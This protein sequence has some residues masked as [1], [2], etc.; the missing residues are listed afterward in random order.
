MRETLCHI[1]DKRTTT[2]WGT[3]SKSR[4]SYEYDPG[5][6]SEARKTVRQVRDKPELTTSHI[7]F[8][9]HTLIDADGPC[10]KSVVK[11]SMA[12]V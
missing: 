4:I 6:V 12:F 2:L 10:S 1:I 7:I 11:C 3:A 5:G 8:I 9:P